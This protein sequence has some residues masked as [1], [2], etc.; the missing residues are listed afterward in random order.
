MR[1]A[2]MR[3]ADMRTPDRGQWAADSRTADGGLGGAGRL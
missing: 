3:T 1:T 2:D